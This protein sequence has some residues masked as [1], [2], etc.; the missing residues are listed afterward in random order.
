M[1]SFREL[2]EM[3]KQLDEA[4]AKPRKNGFIP[5][6]RKLTDIL[7][8]LDDEFQEWLKE[9]PQEYN[10]KTWKKKAEYSR[11]KELKE[12]VDILAFYLQIFNFCY[13]DKNQFDFLQDKFKKMENYQISD[14]VLDV[15][16]MFKKTFWG[17][18]IVMSFHYFLKIVINRGFTKKELV[19][20]Y[21]SKSQENRERIDGEW[22][23][24]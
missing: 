13:L 23:N 4:I 21:I 22:S 14:N 20:G 2:L 8:A 5:R 10:F 15:V 24:I 16:L 11:E 19:N 1:K 6:E 17:D 3:Q 9:L 7:L 18:D 12:L